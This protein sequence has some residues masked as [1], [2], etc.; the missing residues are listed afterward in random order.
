MIPEEPVAA[1]LRAHVD[2]ILSAAHL[3]AA[4]RDDVREE[5]Y[6]HLVDAWASG[7][8]GGLSTDE[9]AARAVRDFGEPRR[10]GRQLTGAFHSRLWASTIGVLLPARAEP[11]TRPAIV[12]AISA[13]LLVL[14]G[15]VA[16]VS[17]ALGVT[18]PPVHALAVVVSAVFTITGVRLARAGLLRQ[19]SW[20][21]GAALVAL[22]AM[23]VEG[24]ATWV[25]SGGHTISLSGIAATLV[26][27]GTWARWAELRKWTTGSFKGP[28]RPQVLGVCAL[29]LSSWVVTPIVLGA[30]DPTQPSPDDLHLEATLRCGPGTFDGADVQQLGVVVDWDWER[31]SV[32]A[33]GIANLP[34]AGATYVDGLFLAAFDDPLVSNAWVLI[35]NQIPFDV[36]TGSEA[37]WQGSGPPA[38]EAL[39]SSWPQGGIDYA[40]DWFT[41]QPHHHYRASW[42]FISQPNTE[43]PTP[44]PDATVR[45]QH[46]NQWSVEATVSCGKALSGR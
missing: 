19:Q 1:R 13:L 10:L 15:L 9:A 41:P 4:D 38:Q 35:H 43:S 6:A 32:L 21:V 20:G 3:P 40:I 42:T 25:S 37:G 7:V 39:P 45:Y 27:L 44:W 16:L 11:E 33:G 46:V 29:V 23:V 8:Q 2:A 30:P 28:P 31:T 34:I 12:T 26:L 17:V 22:T 36:E 18:Q 24:M 14:I 5:L